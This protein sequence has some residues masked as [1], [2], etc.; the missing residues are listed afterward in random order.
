MAAGRGTGSSEANSAGNF[1][2]NET[3]KDNSPRIDVCFYDYKKDFCTGC[4]RTLEEIG[5]WNKMAESD[6]EIIL[7]ECKKRL[8]KSCIP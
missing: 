3:N 7:E 5:L 2:M 4:G 6:K 8:K 1:F